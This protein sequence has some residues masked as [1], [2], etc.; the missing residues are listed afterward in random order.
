MIV[1][2]NGVNVAMFDVK[3]PGN[4]LIADQEDQA[5]LEELQG[6]SDMIKIL[7]KNKERIQQHFKNK[8]GDT[9]ELYNDSGRVA[10][11]LTTVSGREVVNTSMLKSL[12][13]EASKACTY[14]SADFKRF[15]LK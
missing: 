8:M 12:F 7:E 1:D 11:T 15:C 2:E 13:P 6:I 10:A 14:K 9:E 4:I 5:M 3:I